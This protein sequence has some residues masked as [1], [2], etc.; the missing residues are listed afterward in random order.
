[1]NLG[2]NA[3]RTNRVAQLN[4]FGSNVAIVE[5]PLPDIKRGEVRVRVLAASLNHRDLLVARGQLS[6]DT[7]LPLVPLCDCAGEV[8]EIGSE[9][10]RFRIGDRVVAAQI[11]AWVSGRFSREVMASA[12]GWA[13]DGVLAEYF[14]GDECGFVAMPDGLSFE[15]AATLP[16]AALAAWNALFEHGDLKPGQTVL[17]QG[18]GGVSSFALQFALAAGARVIATSGSESKL[19]P[20]LEL[21]AT[22]VIHY[23]KQ[24][25]WSRAVLDF[26][27]GAGVDHVVEAGGAGTLDQSI[28]STAVGGTISVIG[29]LTGAAGTFDGLALLTK[30]LRVQGIVGGSVEMLERLSGT[31]EALGIRPVIDRMFEMED[32]AAAMQYIESGRHIGKI[33]I[34]VNG[35]DSRRHGTTR[36]P[37]ARPIPGI[38]HD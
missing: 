18:S 31:I 12:L 34:R 6:A 35:S 10:S 17:V 19:Q 13:A 3:P 21:G 8:T 37:L 22:H 36:A 29:T 28:K 5:R 24:P 14:T 32:I 15:E 30:T 2:G 9:V 38:N 20:L 16:C 7:K 1:M 27:D 4:A 11:P 23:R 26:T 25:D 33:V